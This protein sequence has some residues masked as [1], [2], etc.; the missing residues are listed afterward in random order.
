MSIPVLLPKLSFVVTEGKIIE[1]LKKPGD[2]ITKGEPL[3]VIETEKATEEIE[4]P[5]TGILGPE[6][7]PTGTTVPV[8]TTIGY[9][10]MRGELPPKLDLTFG[11]AALVETSVETA[12]EQPAG[13][14]EQEGEEKAGEAQWIKVS[15]LAR[16]MV[17]EH[18]LDLTKIK[19]TGPDGRILQEDVQALIAV[20]DPSIEKGQGPVTPAS[21]RP[22]T[23]SGVNQ[24]AGKDTRIVSGVAQTILKK[25]P[26]SETMAGLPGELQELS[27]LQRIT[28]E[29]MV[30]SFQT[31]PHFYLNVQVDMSQAVVMRE[32]L[33]PDVEVKTGKRLSFTD[34]LLFVVSRTM[35][36]HP[37]LNA[38]FNNDKLY[39]Y[40]DI[41]LCLAVDTP[42]GLTVA[43]IHQAD[44]Y[45]LFEIAQ[46]RAEMVERA[47]N[48]RLTLDDL[49]GGTFTISNL[50]MFGIDVFNAIINPPQA[51]ILAVGRIAKRP[52]VV[53]ETLEARS[54]MW[55]S[56]SVDHRA[57][58]GAT[59][60][61]F[62]QDLVT[63]LENPYRILVKRE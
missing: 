4:A 18:G 28:A 51:A 62:L 50:G 43:V 17:K 19:G 35:R 10:L 54:T 27:N 36:M 53:N 60:A 7:A 5:G 39:R 24:I 25:F 41:N 22:A 44:R 29:R 11:K 15:P 16:R 49:N 63:H 45:S 26:S 55:L 12:G 8:T 52:I 9:I 32:A 6:L 46:Q 1:W 37:A 33:L 40:Q 3:L 42:R 23:S 2:Q 13:L 21:T 34:I 38:M 14:V 48:N 58:D 20:P 57:A 30:Q 59:A 47:Q 61:L 31:A 56:L